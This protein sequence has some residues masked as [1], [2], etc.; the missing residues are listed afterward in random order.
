M[1][2]PRRSANPVL[3]RFWILAIVAE[4]TLA[5]GGYELHALPARALLRQVTIAPHLPPIVL[6]LVPMRSRSN[7][8]RQD[9]Y[10]P[11]SRGA[12][13]RDGCDAPPLGGFAH[14][15]QRAGTRSSA[16]FAPAGR[17]VRLS[18][19]ESQR[20][21]SRRTDP[22]TATAVIA[23][24]DHWRAVCGNATASAFRGPAAR[25]ESS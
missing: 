15:A 1:V 13:E 22:P 4:W 23:P 11:H 6:L 20:S 19:L 5:R 10:E 8:L 14:R 21:S 7:R 3:S 17:V 18:L 25:I 2:P 12:T 16:A 9:E 24:I